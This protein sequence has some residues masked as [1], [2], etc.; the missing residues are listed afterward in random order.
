MMKMEIKLDE[1]R[2]RKD[3]EYDIAEL[4]Q[5]IDKEFAS[6]CTKVVQ[7]DGSVMY[8]GIED[9]DYYTCLSLAYL[10]LKYTKWFLNYCSKWVWY[11]N[12]DDEELPFSDEDVLQ[13]IRTGV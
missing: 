12:D 2:I 4:W 9:K 1:V 6:A 8:T 10:T 11:D 13:H 5:M 7:P 3:G